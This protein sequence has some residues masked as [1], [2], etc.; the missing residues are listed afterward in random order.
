[1]KRVLAFVLV[2]V[3]MSGNA[4]ADPPANP[5]A[6]SSPPGA[7]V[8]LSSDRTLTAEESVVMRARE[9]LNRARFLDEAAVNDDKAAIDLATRLPNLRVAAKSARDRAD[10]A[11]GAD[12]E[13]LVSK[14]EDLEA[15]LAISEAELAMK[16]R[17][18]AEDR[19]VARDLRARA[20]RLVRDGALAE[21]LA[22][23]ACDPPYRFT[24]DGR[25]IYRVECLK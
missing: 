6:A 8:T 23:G 19:R 4:L 3:A 7:P 13:A 14:A 11:T 2:G 10:R 22:L 15:D 18:A 20:V 21:D 12:K 16:K 17:A 9:M 24:A 25:K 1:M 5:Y